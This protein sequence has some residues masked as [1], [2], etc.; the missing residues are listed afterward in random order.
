[1]LTFYQPDA[2][3]YDVSQ[4]CPLCKIGQPASSRYPNYVCSSC[5]AEAK[6]AFGRAVDFQNTAMSGGYEAVCIATGEV[7]R[8]HRCFI[9]GVECDADEARFGGIVVTPV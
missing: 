6:D 3:P 5:V 7:S 2:D 8:S 1:V 9:R 4:P